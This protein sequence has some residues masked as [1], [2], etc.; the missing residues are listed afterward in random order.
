MERSIRVVLVD[1]HAVVREGLAAVLGRHPELEVVGQAGSAAE[2]VEVS[3]ATQPD[4]VVMD[5]RMPG[6]SGIDACRE[7][8]SRWPGVRILVLT[9]YADDE[10]VLA[11]ISAGASGY[12]LKQVGSQGLVDAIR[13]VAAGEALLDPSVTG[14]VLAEVRRAAL[15]RDPELALLTEQERRI[16]S[17]IAAGKTNREIAAAVYLSEKTVRNYVSGIFAKLNLTNRAEAA[18]F[19]ARKGLRSLAPADADDEV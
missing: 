13:R 16:L 2:A 3:G 1:D 17:L 12:V 18:A 4:V 5:I 15:A 6:G 11:S 14:Q 9:S 10:A 8:T 19:A 7:I